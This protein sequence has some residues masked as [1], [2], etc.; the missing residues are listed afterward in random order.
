MQAD[1]C[2]LGDIEASC[3]TI[4]CFLRASNAGKV[5]SCGQSIPTWMDQ[6]LQLVL[7]HVLAGSVQRP[8]SDTLIRRSG[9]IH[10]RLVQLSLVG[11]PVLPPRC[12]RS[13]TWRSKLQST[14]RATPDWLRGATGHQLILDRE[15]VAISAALVE[16]ATGIS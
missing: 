15:T 7:K 2:H 10:V 8:W 3:E 9:C 6:R 16:V 4:A 5:C 13:A 14:T 12:L 1:P 11:R